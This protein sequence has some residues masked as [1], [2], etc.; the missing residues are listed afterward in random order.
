VVDTDG[1]SIEKY[2][3]SKIASRMRSICWDYVDSFLYLF[4]LFC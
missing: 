3:M 1:F 4:T 2:R